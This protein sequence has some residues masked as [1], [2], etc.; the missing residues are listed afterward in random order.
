MENGFK[1]ELKVLSG[2][3]KEKIFQ[4]ALQVLEDVGMQLFHEEALVGAARFFN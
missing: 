2:E 4:A 1:P 3:D